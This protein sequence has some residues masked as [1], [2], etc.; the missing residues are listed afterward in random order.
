MVDK[1]GILDLIE[2]CGILSAG[3]ALL[4]GGDGGG[5]GPLDQSRR[6]NREEDAAAGIVTFCLRPEPS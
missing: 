5:T 3:P 1:I 2:I 6:R 4:L